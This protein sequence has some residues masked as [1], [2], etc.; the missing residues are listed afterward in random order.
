MTRPL[1]SLG[2]ELARQTVDI[3]GNLP[4]DA[5]FFEQSPIKPEELDEFK[6]LSERLKRKKLHELTDP[7]REKLLEL[8]LRFVPGV[9]KMV[10]LPGILED[11]ILEGR[12]LF[13]AKISEDDPDAV[14]FYQ[15]SEYIHSQ[16]ILNN[17][18]LAKPRKPI[19]R[20]GENL[21]KHYTAFD[22]RR[23]SGDR[24]RNRHVFPGG[25]Q[26][27]Q[28]IRGP[29][30]ETGDCSRIPEKSKNLDYGR[31]HLSAR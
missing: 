31:S 26:G 2:A 16:T 23:S 25:Q 18:F 9:H 7:D 13:R 11:L 12:A 5:I 4:P 15:V 24:H 19:P 1:I 21:S 28:V 30:P 6:V 10:A 8:A 14:T 29:T 22:R 20:P 17:I 3:L 27:R